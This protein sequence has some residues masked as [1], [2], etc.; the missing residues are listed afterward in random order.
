MPMSL[1]QHLYISLF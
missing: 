1:I